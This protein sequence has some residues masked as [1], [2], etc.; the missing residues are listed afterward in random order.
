MIGAATGAAADVIGRLYKV[1]RAGLAQ[2]GSVKQ[3]PV[4]SALQLAHGSFRNEALTW[5]TQWFSAMPTT[6]AARIA[7]VDGPNV[8]T[9]TV[10]LLPPV[11]V[12][13]P[14]FGVDL[15]A[16]GGQLT[17]CAMDVF[18]LAGALAAS[19]VAALHATRA[20][21]A[22]SLRERI[23]VHEDG[24]FS[25]HAIVA[26]CQKDAA[27]QIGAAAIAYFA[28]WCDEVDHAPRGEW[29]GAVARRQGI[30]NYLAR[31]CTH[32]QAVVP[33]QRL[34]SIEHTDRYFP[35]FFAMPQ[36][37]ARDLRG[38]TTISQEDL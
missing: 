30:A 22:A 7:R 29:T 10:L 36:A 14:I 3:L 24:P 15:V 17:F 6:E 32:M 12:A 16:F 31:M 26:S 18:P 19:T 37:P 4:T 8:T 20:D 27:Q 25:P 38:A 5:R 9:L 11:D 33:L 28:A 21:V 1:V 13:A 23:A 2:R 35:A 34:F